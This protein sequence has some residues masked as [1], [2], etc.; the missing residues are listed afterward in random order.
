VDLPRGTV[1]FLFSDVDG[2]TEMVKRLGARYAD[3]L[4]EHRRLLRSAF[5]IH[6]GRE[7]DTQGDAFCVAFGSAIDAILAAV[8][9]QHAIAAHDWDD[10]IAPRVRMGLHTCEPHQSDEGYVGLGLH[11][12]AR[13]CT[14]GHGGQVLLSRSTAGIADDH[15]I[16]GVSGA[17]DLGER[18]LKNFDRPERV[19]QLV[20]DRLPSEFPPLRA[21][22]EQVPLTGTVTIVMS[23][24]RRVI[25]LLR[26]L[27]PAIFGAL[28]N[29]YQRVLRDVLERMGG[30]E[31][32]AFQD[33][34]I[35]AFPT[36]R[37]AALA[38]VAV[39]DAVSAHEWPHQ[40]NL[41]VSVGVHSG[42]A[43]IGWLGPA[44]IR[45]EELCNAAEAGQIFLSSSTAALLE[46]ED[47]RGLHIRDVGDQVARRSGSRVRAFELVASATSDAPQST[48]PG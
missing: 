35:A 8:A 13:I 1:T 21:A 29:E 23:E 34:A 37:E 10:G 46:E 41:M 30:R 31:F 19:Y 40:R 16:A 28:I 2:S 25:R 4:A 7:V 15:E 17:R 26:E 24:G 14:L 47:L 6:R 27:S 33:T 9:A 22:S 36:A 32:E 20:V 5:A 18:A 42:E 43:G 12:A 44:T 48:A 38:A 39:Q 3:V 45:C 11:R